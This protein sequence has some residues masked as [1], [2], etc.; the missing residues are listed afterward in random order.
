VVDV[1]DGIELVGE[2]SLEV[3]ALELGLRPVD[4]ADGPLEAGAAADRE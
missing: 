2:P 4:D 1:D 3:V